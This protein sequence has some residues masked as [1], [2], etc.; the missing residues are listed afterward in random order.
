M[1]IQ[2]KQKLSV[3]DALTPEGEDPSP[4]AV[5]AQ[6]MLGDLKMD[7]EGE[8]HGAGW[9]L[10][11]LVAPVSWF[12]FGVA[13]LGATGA[14]FK[15]PVGFSALS[16]MARQD[17]QMLPDLIRA[18]GYKLPKKLEIRF[19]IPHSISFGVNFRIGRQVELGADCRIWL[20]NFYKTQ[21]IIPYYRA[22]E[23]GE[24]PLTRENLTRDK[25]YR[26]SFQVGGGVLVRPWRKHLGLELMAGLG[27]DHSAD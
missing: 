20:Y 19:P 2:M 5:M 7:Y 15:G 21:V 1:R 9:G 22:E 27:Y 4:T 8:D 12:S 25:D 17:P 10:S 11:V 26:L 3:I 18:A 6:G 24:E 16:D 13:Y 14:A 23:P